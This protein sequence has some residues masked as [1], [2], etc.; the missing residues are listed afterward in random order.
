MRVELLKPTDCH[1]CG[2]CCHGQEALPVGYWLGVLAD[3]DGRRLPHELRGEIE[4]LR[5]RFDRD[6]WPANGEPCVWFDPVRRTCRHYEFRPDICHEFELGGA[7][8]LRIR[9]DNGAP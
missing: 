1:G 2:L 9:A 3:D 8:C 5:R 4:D 6:G 7:D